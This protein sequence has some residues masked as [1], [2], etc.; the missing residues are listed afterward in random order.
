MVNLIGATKT[1]TGLRVKAVLDTGT[2]QK[3]LKV[4][5]E[6]MREVQLRTRWSVSIR[7]R[8]NRGHCAYDHK[9]SC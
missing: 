6:A 2:Y 7:T 3:G 8:W 4:T 9:R 1:R 5:E